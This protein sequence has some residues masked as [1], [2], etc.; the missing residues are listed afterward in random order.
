MDI[1][2]LLWPYSLVFLNNIKVLIIITYKANN[3]FESFD[4]SKPWHNW[5]TPNINDKTIQWA[6][7]PL[8]KNLKHTHKNRIKNE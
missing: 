5:V 4:E 3:F 1:R 7:N 8:L 6:K 2:Q